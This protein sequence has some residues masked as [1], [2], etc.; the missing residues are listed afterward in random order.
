MA[1]AILRVPS[2]IERV[3]PAEPRVP[4]CNDFFGSPVR[5][6]A[7]PSLPKS[8]MSATNRYPGDDDLAS[9]RTNEHWRDLALTGSLMGAACVG[10]TLDDIMD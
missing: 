7:G 8:S 9:S 5:L 3:Y 2:G 10:L 6:D 1:R 4:I